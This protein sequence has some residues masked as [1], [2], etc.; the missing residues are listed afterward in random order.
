MNYKIVSSND[1]I[2]QKAIHVFNILNMK[3]SIHI[4][5]VDLWLI[6]VKTMDKEAIESYKN[7]QDSA[8]L[9]FVVND[10]DDIKTLLY[11][12]FSN[13]IKASFSQVELNSW[14]KLFKSSKKSKLIKIDENISLDLEK[15]ELSYNSK[16]YLLT[17]QEVALIRALISGS[18]ISTK[19]LKAL[20]NLNS[21]TSVRTIINRIRKK[22][23]KDIFI[24]KRDYG[25]KLNVKKSQDKANNSA[26]YIKELEEQNALIQ[27]IVDSSPVYIATFIHKQLFC[28]NKSFRE[29][30]GNDIVKE[31]WDET[32]GDFFQLIRHSLEDKE[33]MKEDLFNKTTSSSVKIYDFKKDGYH[34][35]KV[36]TY[37]FEKIDK[38][39][40]IFS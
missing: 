24:Q 16:N 20:L 40:L 5:E 23:H 38:H 34:E 27:Q 17:K 13:Y 19:L 7:R 11:S 8:F 32:K 15:N 26:S 6:D 14:C 39:L 3:E 22:T 29:L 1:E 30:L 18:F 2:K 33:K 35:F 37:F 12:G 36:Q 9:L 28:I 25:Y 4:Q 10:D 31:L 21:E